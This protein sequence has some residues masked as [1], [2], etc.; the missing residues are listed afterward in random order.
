ME[1]T[2]NQ[3]AELRLQIDRLSRKVDFLY[4]QLEIAYSD[5]DVPLYV[6]QARELVRIG[7]DSEAVRVIRE[8]TAVG[9]LEARSIVEDLAQRLGRTHVN[10]ESVVPP[11]GVA[12]ATPSVAADATTQAAVED[13]WR[14]AVRESEAQRL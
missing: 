4:D 3:I 11:Q 6:V 1:I 13:A 14:R 9:M 7:R 2:T 10:L 8:H 5:G 12:G